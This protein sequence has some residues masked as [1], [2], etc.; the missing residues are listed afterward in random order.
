MELA[1]ARGADCGLFRLGCP[2]CIGGREE[3]VVWF[4][5]RIARC[6][7]GH[8]TSVRSIKPR[9]FFVTWSIACANDVLSWGMVYSSF[10][11]YVSAE[12]DRYLVGHC[13]AR[14]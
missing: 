13:I 6:L 12:D 10:D 9:A 5:A 11:R 8:R 2:S 7:F 1:F 14:P 4:L 3:G